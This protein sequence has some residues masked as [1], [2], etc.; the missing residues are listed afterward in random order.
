MQI[1]VHSLLQEVVYATLVG[2]VCS[3]MA[4]QGDAHRGLQD[5]PLQRFCCHRIHS[6]HSTGDVTV[7]TSSNQEIMMTNREMALKLIILVLFVTTFVLAFSIF[8]LEVCALKGRG[9]CSQDMLA[10]KPALWFLHLI[11]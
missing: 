3:W 4:G 8:S 2:A 11:R 7:N 5:S 6:S 9:A 10:L 1:Q